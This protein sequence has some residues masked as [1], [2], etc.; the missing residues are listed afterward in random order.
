MG[1]TIT[2]CGNRQPFVINGSQHALLSYEEARH[3]ADAA[4]IESA[5]CFTVCQGAILQ[6]VKEPLP[7]IVHF[8]HALAH[9]SY[10]DLAVAVVVKRAGRIQARMIYMV[11]AKCGSIILLPTILTES[12]RLKGTRTCSHCQTVNPA[13][14]KICLA[15][16]CMRHKHH[17]L[18]SGLACVPILGLPFSFTLAVQSC[19]RAGVKITYSTLGEAVLDTLFAV[20]DLVTLPLVA[21]RGFLLLSRYA[22]K[23]GIYSLQGICA[24]MGIGTLCSLMSDVYRPFIPLLRLARESFDPLRTQLRGMD[25]QKKQS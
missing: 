18:F 7:T 21:A 20:M 12:N 14:L 10:Y 5:S 22:L 19:A 2:I 4:Y 8:D 23:F 25:E 1:A 3:A 24:R 15:D 13:D 9:G 17:G 11:R 6:V 16:D